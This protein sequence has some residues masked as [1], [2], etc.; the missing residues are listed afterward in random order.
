VVILVPVNALEFAK[1]HNAP[2]AKR[3][4]L[5]LVHPENAEAEILVATGNSAE[6]NAVHP[7]K[8]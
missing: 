6:V 1:A 5:K 8:A 3:N 4:T 2:F 7:W